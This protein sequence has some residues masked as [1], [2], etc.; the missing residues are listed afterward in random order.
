MEFINTFA[1]YFAAAFILL[2]GVVGL[3]ILIVNFPW[4]MLAV[5]IGITIY[6]S[7]MIY[8]DGPPK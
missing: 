1:K 2:G 4:L 3:T 7:F 8:L 6:G 5:C